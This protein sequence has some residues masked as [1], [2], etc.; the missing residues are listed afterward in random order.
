MISHGRRFGAAA[1]AA[2]LALV[3]AATHAWAAGEADSGAA[4][5]T[6]E[7]G[8]TLP[9]VEPGSVTLS[10]AGWEHPVGFGDGPVWQ[11]ILEDTGV[12]IDW[13]VVPSNEYTTF[14]KTR[15]A[16]AADLPDMLTLGWNYVVGSPVDLH[17]QGATIKLTELVNRFAPNTK[18]LLGNSGHASLEDQLQA[19]GEMFADCAASEDF[20]E[21]VSAFVE[22]RRPTFTGR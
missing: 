5:S 11:Q 20:A 4:G 1:V 8:Y 19:E 6:A 10:Y 9:I 21:G 14:I 16:A 12:E 18:R 7:S 22:K 13:Q 3:L 2:V 15:I 17:A